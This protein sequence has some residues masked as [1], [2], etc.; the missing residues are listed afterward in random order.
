M[1]DGSGWAPI[2][3]SSC[4]SPVSLTEVVRAT[5]SSVQ[6]GPRVRTS[7]MNHLKCCNSWVMGNQDCCLFRQVHVRLCQ[8]SCSFEKRLS[9]CA[10]GLRSEIAFQN[11]LGGQYL[12]TLLH[13]AGGQG[14]TSQRLVTGSP[15]ASILFQLSSFARGRRAPIASASEAP[16]FSVQKI[17]VSLAESLHWC[18]VLAEFMTQR[19]FRRLGPK[20]VHEHREG[21]HRWVKDIDGNG[22][23]L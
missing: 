10:A 23:N 3:M 12:N 17:N 5:I 16:M 13:K 8:N 20:P 6:S 9:V 15:F 7:M 14:C 2:M 18:N 19:C 22:L 21:G 1:R 4:P 11:L